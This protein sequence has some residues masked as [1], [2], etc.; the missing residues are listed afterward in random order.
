M[1]STMR[2]INRIARLSQLYREKELKKYG[3]GG[4]HHTYILNICRQPGITQDRLAKTIF[5]NK[6]NVARQLAFLEKEGFIIR[7]AAVSDARKLEI[8][9]TDKAKAVEPEIRKI[10]SRW[11]DQLLAELP[12]KERDRLL[13]ELAALMERGQRLLAEDQKEL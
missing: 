3:L 10:L 2:Y 8:Y 4:I 11:N 7:K 5:V 1:E 13:Q 12:E 6:S 9:P